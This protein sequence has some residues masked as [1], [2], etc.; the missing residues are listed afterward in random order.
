MDR[1]ARLFLRGFTRPL[2]LIRIAFPLHVLTVREIGR[3]T[4]G[5]LRSVALSFGA[6]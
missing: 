6:L 4:L 2:H 1:F 3:Q 5:Q